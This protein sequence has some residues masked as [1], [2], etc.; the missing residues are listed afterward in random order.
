[1]GNEWDINSDAPA[2]TE[3]YEWR[4][5]NNEDQHGEQTVTPGALM[6]KPKDL[7]LKPTISP[8]RSGIQHGADDWD[9]Q[10]A[11]DNTW[12]IFGEIVQEAD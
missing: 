8:K 1:M 6:I 12:Y 3:K 7:D 2:R 10:S 11:P 5:P 4:I 9:F